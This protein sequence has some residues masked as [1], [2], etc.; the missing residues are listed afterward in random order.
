ML[1]RSAGLDDE[2]VAAPQCFELG[3]DDPRIAGNGKIVVAIQADRIRTRG[4]TLRDE[5]AAPLLLPT[6]VKFGG[7]ALPQLG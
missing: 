5:L 6:R 2:L 7:N 4:N 1:F 3:V